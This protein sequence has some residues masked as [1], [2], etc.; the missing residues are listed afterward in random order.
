M[1]EIAWE[2]ALSSVAIFESHSHFTDWRETHELA[3]E[4][5]IKSRDQRGEAA[6]RYSL[7]SLHML[8]HEF[9]QATSELARAGELFQQLG[10]EYGMALV[11]RN[12]AYLDRISGNLDQSHALRTLQ[13]AG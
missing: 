8:K 11:Q 13:A 1:T 6:M 9:E 12:Q 2:L 3:L 4:T 5:C 7:G 10:D